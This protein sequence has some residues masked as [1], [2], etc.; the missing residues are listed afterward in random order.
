[1]LLRPVAIRATGVTQT[2]SYKSD[3]WYSDTGNELKQE[4]IIFKFQTIAFQK[5]EFNLLYDTGCG[6]LVIR[7]SAIDTPFFCKNT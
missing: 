3:G 4:N 6:G 7:R 5:T 2:R 1:M